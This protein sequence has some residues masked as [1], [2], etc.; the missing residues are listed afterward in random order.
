VGYYKKCYAR[1]SNTIEEKWIAVW[2]KVTKFYFHNRRAEEVVIVETHASD[3]R[4]SR[5]EHCLG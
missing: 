5:S 3:F 1:L 4:E 2:L